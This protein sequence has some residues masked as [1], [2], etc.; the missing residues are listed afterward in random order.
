[1]QEI[2][3]VTRIIDEKSQQL[4]EGVIH[5]WLPHISV[6]ILNVLSSPEFEFLWESR[7]VESNS[8]DPKS[9]SSRSSQKF[10][11]SHFITRVIW[12]YRKLF[13]FLEHYFKKPA[14]VGGI[15]TNG[16][17]DCKLMYKGIY[18]STEN[19]LKSEISNL[20]YSQETIVY[21]MKIAAMK[22]HEFDISFLDEYLKLLDSIITY[23][24]NEELSLIIYEI[25]EC[26]LLAPNPNSL[27]VKINLSLAKKVWLGSC[28]LKKAVGDNSKKLKDKMENVITDMLVINR[29]NNIDEIMNLYDYAAFFFRDNENKQKIQRAFEASF[30]GGLFTKL[31][32]ILEN[33]DNMEFTQM[34]SPPIIMRKIS[35]AIMSSIEGSIIL[36]S[37]IIFEY[38]M[39]LNLPFIKINGSKRS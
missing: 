5:R 3:E 33:K 20:H 26:L 23:C 2:L 19:D 4:G 29:L 18:F 24:K 11:I 15:S 25:Y 21:S 22:L 35:D 14:T 17:S 6:R 32:L 34:N 37:F 36:N 13:L 27:G 38:R 1:M 10:D 30:G 28:L 9:Q 8:N 16:G 7:P 12:I 31:R 39:C